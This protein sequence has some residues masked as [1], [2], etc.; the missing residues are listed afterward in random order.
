MHVFVY[1]G[2]KRKKVGAS[3]QGMRWK[4]IYETNIKFRFILFNFLHLGQDAPL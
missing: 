4:Q 2:K 3:E 1:S